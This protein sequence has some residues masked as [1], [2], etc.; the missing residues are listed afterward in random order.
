[1]MN[2]VNTFNCRKLP[3]VHNKELNVFSYIHHN[4]WFLIIVLAELLVEFFMIGGFPEWVS[5]MFQTTPL[6]AG[7]HWTALALGLGS[8]LVELIAKKTPDSWLEKIPDVNE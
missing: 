1:M 6:T 7:M 2:W 4:L 3:N 8:L 5:R